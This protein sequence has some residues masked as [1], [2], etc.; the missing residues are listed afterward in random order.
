M[1]EPVWSLATL[2]PDQGQWT[3]EEYLAL[4]REHRRV[5]LSDGTIEVLPVPT[6][7]HQHITAALFALV[8][9]WARRSGGRACY[10]GLRLRLRAGRYREPDVMLLAAES[11]RHFRE[12]Y[13]TGADLVIEVVSGGPE[14]RVRDLVKKRREYAEAGVREY[15]IVDPDDETLTVLALEGEHYTER[16]VY[17]RG[18]TATSATFDGLA[19]D[20]AGVLDAD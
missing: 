2:F 15:W 9:A 13:W 7:R 17:C 16:G 3:E 8:L 12:E 19:A 5:E 10:A 20:V 14:D 11:L 18:Q 4:A 1:G 6:Y